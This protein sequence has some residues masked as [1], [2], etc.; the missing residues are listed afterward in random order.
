[1]SYE[2]TTED[3]RQYL[4]TQA[5]DDRVGYCDSA[6]HCLVAQTIYWKYPE[7]QLVS[8]TVDNDGSLHAERGDDGLWHPLQMTPEVCEIIHAFDALGPRG[9]VITKGSLMANSVMRHYLAR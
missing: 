8:I 6:G 4:A 3:I 9:A 2:V 5:D 1:M 7:I